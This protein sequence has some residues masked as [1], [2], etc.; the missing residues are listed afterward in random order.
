MGW[1]Q[2]EGPRLIR[3]PVPKASEEA[4]A[5]SPTDPSY[6][7]AMHFLGVSDRRGGALV[8]PA[9]KKHVADELG[10][11]AAILKEKRKAREA[12]DALKGKGGGKK[13]NAQKGADGE[14]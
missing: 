2:F 4:V 7:G 8:A 6:E 9:L 3:I 11:E 10:R 12:K 5:E 13:A 1:A 14:G